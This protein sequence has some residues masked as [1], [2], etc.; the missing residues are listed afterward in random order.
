MTVPVSRSLRGTARHA[1]SGGR[2]PITHAPRALALALA[3]VATTSSLAAAQGHHLRIA[4]PRGPVHVWRPDGYD[5]ATAV[6]VVYLHGYYTTVDR[7][8]R[9]HQL[10][11][12]FADA[13]INALFIACATPDGPRRK[14]AW[15]SLTSLLATVARRVE[16][17][18]GRRIAIAHSGGHRTLTLWL[19]D[20]AL[21][22]V[23]LLDAL[24]DAEPA[25]RSWIMA[26][27]SH[28]L[29]NLSVLTRS[30]T[31]ALHGAL[32][33][34]VSLGEADNPRSREDSRIIYIRSD[35]GHME[36]VTGGIV[37]PWILQTLRAPSIATGGEDPQSSVM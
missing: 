12:Q 27:H 28:R 17:P 34:T 9:E 20:P 29:I 22:T 35:R 6:V 16:I 11:R 15:G 14:V 25:Y 5:P 21:D 2:L 13:K 10:A 1:P 3:I 4:T 32:A 30:W 33:E 19:D 18:R 8:W 26:S 31:D 37:L 7:A 36:L 24:Y 23:V